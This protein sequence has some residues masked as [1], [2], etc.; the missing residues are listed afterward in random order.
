MKIDERAQPTGW[1][2]P[3]ALIVSGVT[4]LRLAA[5]AF[6]RTDLFVDEA[7]YWFWGQHL[8]FGYFSKPPM[9]AW[10]IRAVTSAAHSDATFWVRMPGALLHGA[11]ALILAALAA[12][13]SGRSAAFWTAASYVTL[14]LTAVGSLLI[15]TDSVMAPFYAAGL[16]FHHRLLQRHRIGDAVLVGAMLGLAC[17]SKYAGIYLAAGMVLAGLWRPELRPRPIEALVI[18]AIAALAL[19]PN[20]AWNLAN[21]F[22]TFAETEQNIGWV[23]QANPLSRLDFRD[24]FDFWSTQLAVAGPVIF[25]AI[26]LGFLRPRRQPYLVAMALPPLLVVSAQSILYQA[27]A[28]WAVGS[29]FAG[30]ILAVA[31]LA[32]LPRWRIG[33]LIGNA[34]ICLAFPLLTLMPDLTY[35]G[36]PVLHRYLGRAEFSRQIIAL[37]KREGAAAIVTDSRDVIADLYYTGADAGLGFHTPVP[38]GRPTNHYEQFYA[39]PESISGRVLLVAETAPSCPAVRSPLDLA[40]SPYEKAHLGAYMVDADCARHAPTDTDDTP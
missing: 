26:L 17:L 6:N 12:R 5:L 23:K 4:V 32:E 2:I 28:N 13:I 21:K 18:A 1:F 20:L 7:Q 19:A 39:L 30:T 3:A 38:V 9:I 22:S 15:S 14:P 24:V 10:L 37:A 31:V 33:S 34:A 29:Y 8:D 35:D 16:F 25:G 27:Y 40:G 36:R 11:T